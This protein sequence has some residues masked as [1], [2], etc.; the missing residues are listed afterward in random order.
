MGIASLESRGGRLQDIS[1]KLQKKN[2][3]HSHWV[4]A[5]FECRTSIGIQYENE[6]EIVLAQA[7]ILDDLNQVI[8][9]LH[10]VRIRRGRCWRGG[11]GWRGCD[12]GCL[13]G[14]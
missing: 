11:F 8:A 3:K 14:G 2:K 9:F 7:V 13:G 1:V 6:Q 5:V 4:N 10:D 12:R